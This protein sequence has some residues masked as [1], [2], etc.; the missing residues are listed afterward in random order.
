MKRDN[1][2]V[3]ENITLFFIVMKGSKVR[4]RET[5]RWTTASIDTVLGIDIQSLTASSSQ[6]L[7]TGRLLLTSC[8]PN[9]TKFA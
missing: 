4:D 6:P 3:Y 1:T 5:K 9:L 7:P 8:S 2:F